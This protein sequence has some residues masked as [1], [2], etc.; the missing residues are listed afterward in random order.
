METFQQVHSKCDKDQAEKGDAKGLEGVN[1]LIE[2]SD[3]YD[4]VD[5]ERHCELVKVE[6]EIIQFSVAGL[7]GEDQGLR[8]ER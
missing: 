5:I 4:Q 8:D 7:G 1:A 2:V 3:T 6:Q